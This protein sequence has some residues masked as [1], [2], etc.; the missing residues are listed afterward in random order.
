MKLTGKTISFVEELDSGDWMFVF[1]DNTRIVLSPTCYSS[2]DS[3][4]VHADVDVEDLIPR[5]P[6]PPALYLDRSGVALF[7][8]RPARPL[9]QG[10]RPPE[11]TSDQ[12]VSIYGQLFGKQA[13]DAR[14]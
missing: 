10:V 2:D 11:V 9:V 14:K 3:D 12:W 8:H 5:P 13:L 7:D 1:T 4:G 6:L